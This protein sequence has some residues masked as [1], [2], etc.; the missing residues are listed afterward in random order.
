MTPKGPA[1]ARVSQP[2]RR[3]ADVRTQARDANQPS[4]ESILV[5]ERD[6]AV[7]FARIPDLAHFMEVRSL[8]LH[9]DV[10]ETLSDLVLSLVGE[11]DDDGSGSR[12]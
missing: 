8:H 10:L 11:E 3:S 2:L 9:A 4:L 1:L 5:E 7:Y 12:G 6:G